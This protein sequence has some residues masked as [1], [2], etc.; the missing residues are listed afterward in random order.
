MLPSIAGSTETA[1]E[2]IWASI[3]SIDN[4]YRY[5]GY[6]YIEEVKLY[7][8][9]A[10]YYNPEIA[11]FLSQDPYY[12]LGNRVIGLYE[13]NVANIRSIMQATVL[14][15]YCGNCPLLFSDISGCLEQNDKNLWLSGIMSDEDYYKLESLTVEYNEA[16]LQSEYSIMNQIHKEAV[17]IRENYYNNYIDDYDYSHSGIIAKESI[18][19]SAAAIT[20]DMGQGWK[21]RIDNKTNDTNH[22]HIH[23]DGGKNKYSQ[24]DD[25]S[26]HDKSNNSKS[27]PPKWLRDEIKNKLGWDWDGN[28]QKYNDKH[29]EVST[30]NY[31]EYKILPMNPDLYI[32]A[33]TTFIFPMPTVPSVS[34]PVI[35]FSPIFA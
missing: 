11:R 2:T 31:H 14:Y 35:F 20:Y 22:R 19:F 34:M 33:P 26:P 8:L 4:P 5:A 12:N 15:T 1:T 9:N 17:S 23:I 30:N 10:R 25:G 24:N 18:I 29:Q 28:S 16:K 6:E 21:V 13:I 7:D 27:N 3:E 32:P